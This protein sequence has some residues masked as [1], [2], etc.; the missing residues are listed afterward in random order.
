ELTGRWRGDLR[1][2]GR[3]VL[4][5][6]RGGPDVNLDLRDIGDPT[7]RGG[8][9]LAELQ[10]GADGSFEARLRE[11]EIHG[12][13]RIR[14]AQ[15]PFRAAQNPSPEGRLSE[16]GYVGEVGPTDGAIGSATIDPA[17]AIDGVLEVRLD[18]KPTL[19]IS[20]RLL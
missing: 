18:L 3:V 2:I 7:S 4:P 8:R 10:S 9:V 13:V 20:G 16:L 17:S 11:P 5:D 1:V 12:P 19:T 15:K 14:A 6:G